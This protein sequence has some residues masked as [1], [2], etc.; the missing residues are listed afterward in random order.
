MTAPETVT[1]QTAH[2][3]QEKKRNVTVLP[4]SI[5]ENGAHTLIESLS[6]AELVEKKAVW[7]TIV[8]GHQRQ[9]LELRAIRAAIRAKA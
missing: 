7:E 8:A 1:E 5:E 9:E 6:L 3:Q 2:P 4:T